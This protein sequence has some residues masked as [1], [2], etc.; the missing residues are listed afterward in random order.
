MK[1]VILIL[2]LFL[3]VLTSINVKA[4]GSRYVEIF[5]I[6]QG[7][8]VKKVQPNTKIE[9]TALKYI[10]GITGIYARFNPIPKK[11]YAVR[12]PFETPAAVQNKF[13]TAF[14]GEIIIMFPED[15]YSPP[16]LMIFE[17]ENKLL[18]FTFTGNTNVLFK[19]LHFKA[20][21]IT[22]AVLDLYKI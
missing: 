21:D 7:K 3:F 5:D 13:I 14:V 22:S 20:A 10:N 19:M 9:R 8:V 6:N 17:G 15:E 16:F 12:I 18:C 1:K 4:Q 2:S 11:G